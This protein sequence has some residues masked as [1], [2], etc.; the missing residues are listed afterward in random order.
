MTSRRTLIREL[1]S[2]RQQGYALNQEEAIIGSSGVAVPLRN[3]KG[4]VVAGV[5]LAFAG[6]GLADTELMMHVPALREA[7]AA[8]RELLSYGSV[9]RYF[10]NSG[11]EVPTSGIEPAVAPSGQEKADRRLVRSV[12]RRGRLQQVLAV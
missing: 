5:S 12:S 11:P 9:F 1:A 4:T 3:S 6:H 2:V 8:L 10:G 7:A